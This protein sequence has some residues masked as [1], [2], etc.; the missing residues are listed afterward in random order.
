MSDQFQKKLK[1]IDKNIKTL[2]SNTLNLKESLKLLKSTTNLLSAANNLIISQ[3]NTINDES[4]VFLI[5]NN[6]EKYYNELLIRE[7]TIAD[8]TKKYN[9]QKNNFLEED[10]TEE[11]IDNEKN[12]LLNKD[13]NNPIE[14]AFI[15]DKN[16]TLVKKGYKDLENI[17][18]NMSSIKNDIYNQGKSI[19]ELGDTIYKNEQKAKTGESLIDEI[20]L[21]QNCVKL[22]LTVLNFLLFV[23]ILA[24]I[25]YKML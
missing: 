23:L 17:Q 9:L 5:N 18:D 4:N 25:I 16:E 21:N 19:N 7:K 24:I 2:N 13:N 10:I 12:T 14:L 8:L 20:I 11:D 15:M 1:I 3:H 22:L 6:L